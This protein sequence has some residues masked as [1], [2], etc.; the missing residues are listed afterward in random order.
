MIPTDI[1]K[2]LCSS[3]VHRRSF[4]CICCEPRRWTD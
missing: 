4:F 1:E 3:M 2:Q